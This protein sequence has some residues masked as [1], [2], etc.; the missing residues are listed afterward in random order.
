MKLPELHSASLFLRDNSEVLIIN[1][2]ILQKK[3]MIYV[4]GI[5]D[6]HFFKNVKD[7]EEKLELKRETY[8][9]NE[10]FIIK[11]IENHGGEL[12]I[13][14]VIISSI[15]FNKLE[16]EFY[17]YGQINEKIKLNKSEKDFI[18]S[19][20]F[21]GLSIYYDSV[22]TTKQERSLLG[23]YEE[24]T[25]TLTKD[26]IETSA[27][28]NHAGNTV[29]IRF[30]LINDKEDDLVH[31]IFHEDSRLSLELYNEIKFTILTFLS[32]AC[33]NNINVRR[34]SFYKDGFHHSLLYSN[35]KVKKKFHSNFIPLNNLSFLHKN[36]LNDYMECFEVFLFINEHLH[37]SQI[38]LLLNQAKKAQVDSS[39]FIMLIALEKLADKYITSPFFTQTPSFVVEEDS[40]QGF[41]KNIKSTFNTYFRS[42][43]TSA[44]KG[45][46]NNLWSRIVNVNK[47]GKTEDKIEQL[48]KF[49]EIKVTPVISILFTVLRNKAIHQGEIHLPEANAYENKLALE[50]LLNRIISN[51]IQYRGLRYLRAEAG[52]NIC[53]QKKDYSIDYTVFGL[54]KVI[55]RPTYTARQSN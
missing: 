40:F 42:D 21:E 26:F 19:I 31:L 45:Q 32:F 46:I 24:R 25:L 22:T 33:G 54:S 16:V 17:C 51:L 27:S 43:K 5:L 39:I 6:N 29:D 1:P 35:K 49:A 28:F 37:L 38:I 12:E 48:L 55:Q 9:I 36:V 52:K 10:M 14:P 13:S 53:E 15:N 11:G 50:L 47:K 7:I 41:I 3:G 20:S 30:A 44:T 34:E 23:K 4:S 2:K 8:T 18:Y